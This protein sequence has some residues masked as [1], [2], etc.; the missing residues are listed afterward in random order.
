MGTYY[1]DW[2]LTWTTSSA[3]SS[4]TITNGSTA[5]SESISND[6]KL[7]TEVSVEIAYGS[8]ASAGVIVYVCG[9]IDGTN[10]EAIADGPWGFQ[11]NATAST[12]V[13]RRFSVPSWISRF[14]IILSNPSGA[15]VT[16]TVRYQQSV[17]TTA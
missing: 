4:S 13:R 17:G 15:S 14:K 10:Y 1:E 7:T 9:D 5:T 16:A 3:I 11:M 6:L 12:T 2:P 8:P